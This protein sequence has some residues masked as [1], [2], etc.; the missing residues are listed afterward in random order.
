MDRGPLGRS[1]KDQP[2]KTTPK[3]RLRHDDSQIQFAAI[4]SSPLASEV[5]DSQILTDRQREVRERQNFEAGVMFPD[6]R[7]ILKPRI[8]ERGEISPKLILKGTQVSR[9]ELDPDDSCPILRPIDDILEDVFVSSPTPKS[10]GRNSNQ[11]SFSSGPPSLPLGKAQLET[12]PYDEPPLPNDRLT[13]REVQIEG[14]KLNDDDSTSEIYTRASA[15]PMKTPKFSD[16]PLQLPLDKSRER[17]LASEARHFSGNSSDQE[18]T[19]INPPSDFDVFVDAPSDPLPTT[20]S[21]F[22][23]QRGEVSMTSLQS[24]EISKPSDKPILHE[25][26]YEPITLYSPGSVLESDKS[27]LISNEEEVK[28]IMDSFQGSE[29][30]Y[31]PSEDEQIAAQLVSDLERASSQAEAEMRGNASTAG[32]TEKACKKRKVPTEKLGSAKRVKL[33]PNPQVVQV[34]I[35]SRKPEAAD[36]N[37]MFVDG[38]EH[39][40]LSDELGK[41]D[42]PSSPTRI[43]R[44]STRKSNSRRSRIGRSRSLTPSDHSNRDSRASSEASNLLPIKT[45]PKLGSSSGIPASV[46]VSLQRQPALFRQSSIESRHAQRSPSAKYHEVDGRLQLATS[47]SCS[48]SGGEMRHKSSGI[49]EIEREPAVDRP[50]E[51]P[52]P[53]QEIAQDKAIVDDHGA[54]SPCQ[55][56]EIH[57]LATKTYQGQTEIEEAA[58]PSMMIGLPSG[59]DHILSTSHGLDP[60]RA[61]QQGFL[62]TTKQVGNAMQQK[63][64]PTAQGIISE[65]KCLLGGIR[66]VTFNAEEEREMIGSLFECVREVHE[67]GRRR[68]DG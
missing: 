4:E 43:T 37:C 28:W 34:A 2:P 5:P 8:R 56:V 46:D 19:D 14:E 62:D 22:Q 3:A 63:Q 17:S 11:R 26:T 65:L 10:S 44:A 12:K 52:A 36:D 58:S 45:K 16:Q 15:E 47:S 66:Q 61:V 41:G 64:E 57:D 25:I 49:R 33:P 35:E 50:L 13:Q 27:N 55:S 68:T 59:E 20:E 53:C 18:M 29:R 23:E 67:S 30:S 42:H 48:I 39:S 60:A 38:D 24:Q 54:I 1:P 51:L 9:T 7:S 32:Q 40:H 6:L 31:F 21:A